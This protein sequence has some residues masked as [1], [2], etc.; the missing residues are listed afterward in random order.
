MKHST[1]HSNDPSAPTHQVW[2]S[3]GIIG[4]TLCILHCIGTPFAIGALSALGLGFMAGEW[5][6]LLL[7]FVL[8]AIAFLAFI[9]GWR[10]HGS[11]LVIAL[12]IAGIVSILGAAL[13]IED[14]LGHT[15]EIVFTILGSTLLISAHFLN[16]RLSRAASCCDP[17]A[18]PTR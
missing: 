8:V 14:L 3:F 15:M 7:A 9:P 11:P 10:K 17:A 16:W 4:S 5:F 2:D 1:P 12:G 6:H 18:L 13:V